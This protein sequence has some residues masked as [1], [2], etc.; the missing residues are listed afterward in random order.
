MEQG[1]NILDDITE[2][3]LFE[4][5]PKRS[6]SPD[7]FESGSIDFEFDVPSLRALLLNE[8]FLRISVAVE[9]YYRSGAGDVEGWGR[10]RICDMVAPAFNAPGNLFTNIQF[11]AG[12]VTVDAISSLVPQIG[13][14]DARCKTSGA[15]IEKSGQLTNTR[16]GFAKRLFELSSSQL[17]TAGATTVA[18]QPRPNASPSAY[19][20]LDKML[21][22]RAN[23]LATTTAALAGGVVTFGAVVFAAAADFR[24][25]IGATI[26]INGAR[27]KCL[28]FATDVTINVS[29][30]GTI[31]A[32]ND[33]YFVRRDLARTYSGTNDLQYCFQPALGVWKEA[34]P[35]SSGSYALRMTPTAQY[36]QAFIESKNTNTALAAAAN[37]VRVQISDMRLYLK[38]PRLRIPD[39]ISDMSFQTYAAQFRSI[40]SDQ[41]GTYQF[42]VEA[43]TRFIY[44][45]L[46][47]QAAGN[48]FVESVS[49]FTSTD[50]ADLAISYLTVSYGGLTL[51]NT[52]IGIDVTTPALV[53]ILAPVGTTR[54][55]KQ[56]QY[57]Y[58]Q[59]MANNSYGH[60]SCAGPSETLDQ[61]LANG[62][63]YKFDFSGLDYQNKSTDVIVD[64]G[65]DSAKG[66]TPRNL[67][68][69]V[70]SEFNKTLSITNANGRIVKVTSLSI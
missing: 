43:S 60:K 47:N 10:P 29:P 16:G 33:W 13:A 58:D 62:A 24:P 53:N 55:T 27:Y 3:V 69:G 51:P 52:R 11:L 1:G 57:F 65:F 30:E 42:S 37:G 67:R 59:W 39:S 18:Q 15:W 4:V 8:S 21:V 28:S 26:V 25:Y 49:R 35:F 63:I 17:G 40:A 44:V 70:V 9:T 56:I 36:A 23:A 5:M 20:D 31:A 7:T 14:L 2:S 34:Y 22:D 61:Y 50:Y 6:I 38:M 48:S 19:D 45:F 32:T 68:L 46:Q 12:G 41:G 64:I 54:I 66:G